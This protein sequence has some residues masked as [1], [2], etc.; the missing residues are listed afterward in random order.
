MPKP[1][2]KAPSSMNTQENRVDEKGFSKEL[3]RRVDAP[4]T[5]KP[6]DK[7]SDRQLKTP[8]E[9][10][11]KKEVVAKDTSVE[12]NTADKRVVEK[13]VKKDSDDKSESGDGKLTKKADTKEERLKKFMDSLESEFQI[14]PTRIVEAFSEL[15]PEELSLPADESIDRVVGKLNLDEEST[16]KVKDLYGDLV[17]DLETIDTKQTES[18]FGMAPSV[19]ALGLTRERFDKVKNQREALQKSLDQMNQSF[20]QPQVNPQITTPIQGDLI[21]KA[22]LAS[23]GRNGL[24]SYR[25]ISTEN[26]LPSVMAGLTPG[27]LA[28][29]Q[30]R[31]FIY[32]PRTGDMYKIDPNVMASNNEGDQSFSAKD[33]AM[34]GVA[35][36]LGISKMKSDAGNLDGTS[37]MGPGYGMEASKAA[38]PMNPKPNQLANLESLSSAPTDVSSAMLAKLANSSNSSGS[39]SSDF[40]SKGGGGSE[41]HNTQVSGKK[42]DG[43]DMKTMLA[44][45]LGVGAGN[46]LKESS[47]N[48]APIMVPGTNAQVTQEAT[49]RNVQNVMQQAQYLVKAG[50]GEMKVRMTPEGLGEIQ[51]SVELKDGKVQLHMAAENKET[52]KMLESSLSDLR[53]SLSQQK[54]SLESVKI[55]TVARTNTEN[56]ANSNN[57]NQFGQ[58]QNQEN[59]DTRQFWNQFQDQFGGGRPGRESLMDGLK[60]KGYAAKKSETIAPATE[61]SSAGRS[62]GKSSSLNLVA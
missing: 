47:L 62:N 34:M 45:S 17:Q 19:A 52:K 18:K 38:M 26:T 10:S 16:A 25:D 12:Q 14:P 7:N 23:K 57:S 4:G 36:A 50:G 43:D 56:H 61:T 60:V 20:W 32:D 31:E 21:A 8:G 22:Q 2:A 11:E 55:D 3:E 58:N 1:D 59:R 37:P 9:K 5:K 6:A 53:E 33:A 51:L 49:D 42:T 27:E 28:M 44:A 48:S 35:A 24:D 39:G 29:D 13:K 15:S 41:S 46:D 30:N 54:I 40:F